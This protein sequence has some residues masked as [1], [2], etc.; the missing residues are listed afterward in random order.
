MSPV[1]SPH[2]NARQR[3][4]QLSGGGVGLRV[5]SRALG[6]KENVEE[7]GGVPVGRLDPIRFWE[8]LRFRTVRDFGGFFRGRRELWV[9]RLGLA[10]TAQLPPRSSPL[11]PRSYLK[12]KLQGLVLRLG[13]KLRR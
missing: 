2:L 10:P 1:P 11:A 4:E 13:V 9:L 3:S 12:L 8:T 5:G 7:C 6:C